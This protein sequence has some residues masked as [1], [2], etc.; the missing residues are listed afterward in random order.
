M[1]TLILLQC[2][3]LECLCKK[4]KEVFHRFISSKFTLYRTL[5]A[6]RTNELVNLVKKIDCRIDMKWQCLSYE[7]NVK[8]LI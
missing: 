1:K 7:K 5:C 3:K 2:K 6:E 8:I 4:H